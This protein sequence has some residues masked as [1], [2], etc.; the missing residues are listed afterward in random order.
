MLDIS[1]RKALG[2]FSIDAAFTVGSGLTALFGPSGAG[3]TMIAQM[4]AGLEMPDDGQIK[5]GDR[6]LFDGQKSVNIPAQARKIGF[7]F[8]EHRLFPH[9][10]VRGNLTY[11]QR[12][13]RAGAPPIPFDQVVDLLGIGDLLKRRP[14]S[15]SVGEQQRVAIG[16]ALLSNPDFLI[17]DE[18]LS[19]LDSARK[20]DIIP[21]ISRMKSEFGLTIIYISH[22][23]SEITRL[24][25]NLVLLNKGK[26]MGAGPITEIVNNLELMPYTGGFDA[27]SVIEATV[28]SHD[29]SFNMSELETAGGP[30]YVPGRDQP[31]GSRFRVRI[32]AR[33][34]ALSAVEPQD[35]SILNRF[36]GK[37]IDHRSGQAGMEELLLDVGFQLTARITRKSFEQMKLTTGSDVWAMIKSVTIGSS[38]HD[39]HLI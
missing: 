22:S 3:K 35:I 5:I 7:V 34:V 23:L 33:D 19:S 17:M 14:G 32:R 12:P 30:M 26:V 8:Q 31:V 24:A 28:I 29:S 27:G 38:D 15:L 4:L 11:G 10:S 39:I 6:I 9:Y 18:P 2:D 20:K 21:L 25:D 13:P 1:I 36:K 37:V 16:R